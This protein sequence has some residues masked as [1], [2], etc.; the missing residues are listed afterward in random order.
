MLPQFAK[1]IEND[2]H[3]QNPTRKMYKKSLKT[4]QILKLPFITPEENSKT[5]FYNKVI[6]YSRP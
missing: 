3:L 2:M 6:S 5:S 4:E 1:Q